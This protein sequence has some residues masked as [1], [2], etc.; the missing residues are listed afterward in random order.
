MWKPRKF[1]D[2]HAPLRKLPSTQEST[3][4]GGGGGSDGDRDTD[5]GISGGSSV[6][7]GGHASCS[8]DFDDLASDSLSYTEVRSEIGLDDARSTFGE[9]DHLMKFHCDEFQP[10]GGADDEEAQEDA[11]GDLVPCLDMMER[12]RRMTLH[13]APIVSRKGSTRGVR[14]RVRAAIATFKDTGNS[15]SKVCGQNYF[16]WKA[17]SI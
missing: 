10:A 9:Y 2:A 1:T 14:G 16:K 15:H 5:S 3:Y 17:V 7:G 12:V 6:I 4:D 13:T 11:A 8:G